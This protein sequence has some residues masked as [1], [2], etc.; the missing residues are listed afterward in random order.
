M[1]PRWICTP[2]GFATGISKVSVGNVRNTVP[3]LKIIA[4]SCLR[5]WLIDDQTVYVRVVNIVEHTRTQKKQPNCPRPTFWVSIIVIFFLPLSLLYDSCFFR[6]STVL[7]ETGSTLHCPPHGSTSSLLL[8]IEQLPLM[9]VF[10]SSFLTF[11]SIRI[12]IFWKWYMPFVNRRV[13][14]IWELRLLDQLDTFSLFSLGPVRVL[15]I[16]HK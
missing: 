2:G 7:T 1:L 16:C 5:S 4:G 9:G 14:K 6:L 3:V 8:L 13:K 15:Y 12:I 10:L 11:P